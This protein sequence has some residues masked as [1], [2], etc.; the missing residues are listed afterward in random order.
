MSSRLCKICNLELKR[1]E[2]KLS[3]NGLGK[4]HSECYKNKLSEQYGK[5]Y[6]DN[7][8]EELLEKERKQKQEKRLKAKLKSEKLKNKLKQDKELFFNY[9]SETYDFVVTTQ[10]Y[11]K[12]AKINNGTYKGLNEEISCE[13]LLYMF[14]TKKNKLYKIY[15]SNKNKGKNFKD[16][17]SLFN[18]DLAIILSKYDSYK[19]WK[20]N[21]QLNQI[22]DEEKEN[23][24]K[25]IEVLRYTNDINNNN[26][27]DDISNILDE[28]F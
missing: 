6:A 7:K 28:V 24:S 12:I 9:I 20:E 5:E 3:I 16:G 14:K 23:I 11:T 26:N 4:V 1:N 18:Y 22:N 8:I 25:N 2:N 10:I 27:E 19:R 17:Y 15:Q 21:Q 13:D